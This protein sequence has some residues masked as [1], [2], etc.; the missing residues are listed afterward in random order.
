VN[1]LLPGE[2]PLATDSIQGD[3]LVGFA[4]DHQTL[5]GLRVDDPGAAR[6]WLNALAEFVTS[7]DDVMASR[8][9]TPDGE[10]F[11]GPSTAWLGV[12]LSHSALER[13][14]VPT[15]FA[16]ALFTAGHTKDVA[17]GFGDPEPDPEK[18]VVNSPERPIDVLLNIAASDAGPVSEAVDR[19]VASASAAGLSE[20]CREIGT[21]R[22]RGTE[23]FGFLDGVSQPGFLGT[24][25]GAPATPVVAR[26]WDVP[27]GPATKVPDAAPGQP[28]LWPGEFVF[29]HLRQDRAARTPGAPA[30]AKEGD[31]ASA[32]ANDGS[33]LVFRR[34]EQD[35][36]AFRAFVKET[37]T[38]LDQ[39]GAWPDMTPDLLAAMIV[40]RWPDGAP[41]RID[42]PRDGAGAGPRNDFS[43]NDDSSGL[44]CPLSAH[45]R[46]VNPRSGPHDTDPH[47]RRILRRGIPFG[48]SFDGGARDDSRGLL[49]LCYQTSI[50]SQFAFLQSQ[51]MNDPNLPAGEAG[52]DMLV[53]QASE[54]N[55][56][57]RARGGRRLPPITTLARWIRPTGGQFLFAPS[58]RSLASLGR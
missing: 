3:V 16:D 39:G 15:R 6:A 30:V 41:V 56:A 37:A 1:G 31:A 34:L 46:K 51:W 9:A 17:A 53:G 13:L 58:K 14:G 20:T 42:E 23:H 4:S 5:L 40:G 38:Q 45:I 43:F 25:A 12:A 11:R 36:A 33:L 21:R 55:L 35:V 52:H 50:D 7:V 2:P 57:L 24:R 54:R 19:L 26:P 49:F 48:S 10:R 18:W 8:A 27:P 28:L 29:G 32:W 47:E 44:H 22:D